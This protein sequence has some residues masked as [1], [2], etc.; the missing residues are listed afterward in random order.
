[1]Y[2]L[3]IA[4]FLVLVLISCKV[5]QQQQPNIVF[6]YADQWRAQDVGY[7]GNKQVITPSIDKLS[8]EGINMTSAV[9]NI[10]VCAPARASLLSGQYPLTHGV[11]YNDKAFKPK[12]LTLA[13]VLK[14]N[15]YQTAYIGKWHLKGHRNGETMQ[16]SR[17]TPVP[18]ESRMGFDYW[19]VLECTHNYNNSFYFDENDERHDWEGYDAI[20]Q[21]RQAIDYIKN[22]DE[23]PFFL[24]LSWGPPH[25]PYHSAPEEYK[26]L[27]ENVDIQLR[28]NVPEEFQE[29]ASK[30]IK[31]YYAHCSALDYCIGEL[32]KSIKEAGIE[33]NTIF[34][35]TSDHGDMLYSHGNQKKQQPWDESI[36]VPFLLKYPKLIGSKT[37]AINTPFSHPDIMPTLLGLAG[38]E[39]PE[40]VEGIDFSNHMQ[41]ASIDVQAALISCPVPFHQW[42]Y[43]K[44]GR[45]YR[46]VRTKR[47]TYAKDLESAWVLYDN[48]E[49]PYQLNNLVGKP[50][51]SAIQSEL[52]KQ[53]EEL[54]VLRNDEFREGEFYMK[55]WNYFWDNKDSLKIEKTDKY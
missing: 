55:K 16:V 29:V 50:E 51:F 30:S 53:L 12:G 45:E 33:E 2:K 54:L 27:Y 39:I 48:L 40:S 3:V 24:F 32:Q 34:V 13:E 52:E 18:K 19:K 7:T 14:E 6:V 8:E 4:F 10:P 36:L 5:K 23:N 37:K 9:S 44:G 41:G 22:K 1:M 46:G 42:N 31:G 21:T 43:L 26:A 25:A 17:T 28:P 38:V 49:D 15:G 11:F 35:F 47:Y 20:A